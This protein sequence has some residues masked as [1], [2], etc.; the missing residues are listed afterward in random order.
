MDSQ[1][2]L[3]CTLSVN[4]KVDLILLLIHDLTDTQS[5]VSQ[6]KCQCNDAIPQDSILPHHNAM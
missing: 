4:D 2:N 3:L 1:H 5:E 6:S